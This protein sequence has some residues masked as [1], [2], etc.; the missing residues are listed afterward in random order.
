MALLYKDNSVRLHQ[1]SG[2][3]L[4]ERL[5]IQLNAPCVSIL[6]L[7]GRLL[8]TEDYANR[9]WHAIIEFEVVGNHLVRRRE[10]LA[11]SALVSVRSWC[12][13]DN[14]LVICTARNNAQVTDNETGEDIS[15]ESNM[16][17]LLH[18]NFA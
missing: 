8:V 14:G 9:H 11:S 18:Y 1:L 16:H 12:A 6:W 17:K 13:T 4:E 5:H 7:A 15:R 2:D 10:L 3:Q